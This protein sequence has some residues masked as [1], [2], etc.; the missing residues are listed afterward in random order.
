MVWYWGPGRGASG[1]NPETVNAFRRA[2]KGEDDGIL[3]GWKG[4]TPKIRHFRDYAN[5]YAGVEPRPEWFGLKSWGE[6]RP[7]LRSEYEAREK[8]GKDT[9]AEKMLLDLLVHYEWLKAADRIG[10]AAQEEGGFFQ[11]LPNPEDLSNGNDFLFLAGLARV[12]GRTEEYFQSPLYM[13]GA[14]YRF[15]YFRDRTADGTETGIVLEAGGGGNGKPYYTAETSLKLAY[16]VSLATQADHLEG[17]FWWGFAR[18]LAELAKEPLHR[19][20]YG[21]ILAYG[22][23]FR[24]AREDAKIERLKP[25]FLS[26]TSRRLF[27]PWGTDYRAWN[28]RLNTEFSP[29]RDLARLGYVFA[30]QGA[31]SLQEADFS[32]KTVLFSAAPPT[33]AEWTRFTELLTSGRIADGIV[34]WKMDPSCL[35]LLMQ[36]FFLALSRALFSAGRSIAARIAIIAITTKSSINVNR[37]IIISFFLFCRADALSQNQP[38]CSRITFRFPF[39]FR[40]RVLE[41]SQGELGQSFNIFIEVEADAGDAGNRQAGHRLVVESYDRNILR[42]AHPALA[43]KLLGL[44]GK[45]VI[46]A[47]E[48]G[49]Q[50][51]AGTQQF[52]QVGLRRLRRDAPLGAELHAVMPRQLPDQ[53]I[54]GVVRRVTL[55]EPVAPDIPDAAVAVFVEKLNREAASLGQIQ[56]EMVDRQGVERVERNHGAVVAQ[57]VGER[58]KARHVQRPDQNRPRLDLGEEIQRPRLPLELLGQRQAVRRRDDG[59]Q[60]KT[61]LIKTALDFLNQRSAP[62]VGRLFTQT[63]PHHAGSPVQ[64]RT[65]KK[66]RLIPHAPGVLADLFGFFQGDARLVVQRIADGNRGNLEHLGDFT[67]GHNEINLLS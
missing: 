29:D 6:Y 48:R 35:L 45:I 26:L 13:N 17:D 64:Q 21:A 63:E 49:R 10:K 37:F 65:G 59:V 9:T 67:N 11:V 3:L 61:A 53:R 56:P 42:N 39:V 50:R 40:L 18:P 27:R 28:W 2:L 43:Q 46:V 20:R 5:Y 62:R 38:R 51:R 57:H 30:G 60:I 22:L 54:A 7:L 52:F 12:G 55:F 8:A 44:Q 32:A 36:L 34:M 15:P 4:E 16:E 66:G 23:G 47:E 41:R 31:E 14:Y 58:E 25:D 1:Y 24:Y 33:E 19:D